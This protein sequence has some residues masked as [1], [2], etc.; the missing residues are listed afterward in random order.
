MGGKD[1]TPPFKAPNYFSENSQCDGSEKKLSFSAAWTSH[2]TAWKE[3]RRKEFQAPLTSVPKEK[4]KVEEK[5]Y[6]LESIDNINVL[7]TRFR[8]AMGELGLPE[9]PEAARERTPSS[10]V[11]SSPER[12][13][14]LCKETLSTLEELGSALEAVEE[15]AVALDTP[16]PE[17]AMDDEV[18][19]E[20]LEAAGEGVHEKTEVHLEQPGTLTRNQ[21][22][23]LKELRRK[24]QQNAQQQAEPENKV[25]E[26]EGML[27]S[28]GR[29]AEKEEE[30][31]CNGTESFP[32]MD[33]AMWIERRRRYHLRKQRF[34]RWKEA[35]E[36]A[37]ESKSLSRASTPDPEI[38]M[39]RNQLEALMVDKTT[40]KE[41]NAQL[42]RQ[43]DN[44]HEIVSYISAANSPFLIQQRNGQLQVQVCSS[45]EGP[46][47]GRS[48]S[49]V[50]SPRARIDP[51]S[52]G[53]PGTPKTPRTPA[54]LAI[55]TPGTASEFYTP[56]QTPYRSPSQAS[57]TT[58]HTKNQTA[59]KFYKAMTQTAS[60]GKSRRALRFPVEDNPP[61]Q[62]QQQQ[63]QNHQEDLPLKG[64]K[65]ID[66]YRRSQ[67]G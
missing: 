61:Q 17:P 57:T 29:Q 43:N 44:L 21:K 37:K 50:A 2:R 26:E 22:E 52:P 11:A 47:R 41:A 19:R 12:Q 1:E 28:S 31:G 34:K 20:T 58:K 38:F 49:G 63:Q 54:K 55:S 32:A 53:T 25:E 24:Q 46:Q 8:S 66:F 56:L 4:A 60:T 40:L 33:V 39:L 15:K 18:S 67:F 45:K 65:A 51:G 27:A 59:E 13:S 23:R 30:E 62:Q 42:V 48:W 35:T 64:K 7:L 16:K 10:E 36:L 5:R 9:R 3:K 14:N 6:A